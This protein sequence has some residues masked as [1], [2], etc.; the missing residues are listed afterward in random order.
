MAG[1]NGFGTSFPSTDGYKLDG[2]DYYRVSAASVLRKDVERSFLTGQYHILPAKFFDMINKQG[3]T[4]FRIAMQTNPL[5][6]TVY[7]FGYW[8]NETVN[9]PQLVVT[10]EQ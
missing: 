1:K 2:M 8:E 5:N 4:Q 10:W 3:N 6:K 7:G 9:E